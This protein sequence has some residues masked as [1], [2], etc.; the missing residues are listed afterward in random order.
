A[1]SLRTF[2][3]R[4]LLDRVDRYFERFGSWTIF[5]ARFI[6]GI[7]VVIAVS[8]GMSGFRWRRF[9]LWNAAGAIAWGSAIASI[10]WAFGQSWHLLER[11]VGRGGLIAAGAVVA[12]AAAAFFVHRWKTKRESVSTRGT[13][14]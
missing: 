1:F 14:R 11:D 10:G 5:F 7:R 12:L 9:V 3:P 4:R 13:G 6:T 2:L 8:A